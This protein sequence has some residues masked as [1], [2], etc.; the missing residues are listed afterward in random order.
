MNAAGVNGGRVNAAGARPAATNAACAAWRSL[1]AFVASG[2]NLY[3]RRLI[4]V[5]E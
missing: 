2:Q 1:V 3:R 5:I 4:E